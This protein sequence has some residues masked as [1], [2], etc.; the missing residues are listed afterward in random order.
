[1]NFFNRKPQIVYKYRDWEDAFHKQILVRREIFL[2]SASKLNDPFDG[3]I[4]FEYVKRDLTSRKI[5][6]KM[7]LIAKQR[8][9]LSDKKTHELVMHYKRK[10]LLF[11]K[12][13]IKKQQEELKKETENRIGIFSLTPNCS[14]FLMWSHYANSH[15][16][17]CVGFNTNV[18]IESLKSTFG[19][20]S[21]TKRIPKFRL[22]DSDK[23][24]AKKLLG[25]KGKIWKYENEFRFTK[26]DY[27]NKVFVVPKEA[28]AEILIGNK[29]ENKNRKE[30][31][32]IV[33]SNYSSCKVYEMIQSRDRFE[34]VKTQ[35]KL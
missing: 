10:G 17:F 23:S 15:T 24:F 22:F 18:L 14:N 25:T 7:F 35:L 13:H 34:L 20:I 26:F 30:I 31:L 16:G 1:M 21:Y 8:F 29:M 33:R 11:D 3:N 9:G 32:E 5:Y 19:W 4:P 12:N 2:P 6:K 28:L 27:A